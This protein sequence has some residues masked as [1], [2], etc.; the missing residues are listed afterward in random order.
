[1]RTRPLEPCQGGLHARPMQEAAVVFRSN[2]HRACE[3]R[4]FVLTAVGI[5]SHVL[6]VEGGFALMVEQPLREHALH[7]LWQY[8][9]ERVHRPRP[10]QRFEPQPR[11]WLG[12]VVYVLLLLLPPFALAQG[13]LRTDPYE[14]A[15]LNPALIRGGEW[16]RALTALTLHWDAA[17]LL[18]NLGGGALLGYSAAQVWGNA[19]AWL[20]IFLAAVLA[21][22]IEAWVGI[23]NY[24]SAGAS[25]AVFA[26]LGLVTAFAWRTR[27]HRFGHP[28]ARWGPLVAGVA[29]LGFFGAGSNVPVAGMPAPDLL[30]FEDSGSTNVLAHLLG[31]ACGVL[32]GVIA[33]APRGMLFIAFIP[34]RLAATL[35]PAAL[36]LAWVLAQ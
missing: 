34:A 31:F 15:T 26:A 28:L 10:P 16:W 1:M 4:A 17:H 18:G 22:V 2:A 29:M 9:Q 30:A 23:P 11:A 6:P 7:H 12:S 19:R 20:L 8:E 24:V 3:E 35:I 13:W 32:A 27:G 36:A 14:A 5:D 21:N 25:T 33:A